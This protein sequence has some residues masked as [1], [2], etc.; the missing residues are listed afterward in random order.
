MLLM[1]SIRLLCV[2]EDYHLAE[3]P[4]QDAYLQ[5]IQFVFLK[6]TITT[7]YR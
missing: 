6:A 3:K 2:T 1:M 7:R 5:A 4:Q